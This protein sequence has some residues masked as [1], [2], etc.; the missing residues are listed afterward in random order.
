M[1]E[2]PGGGFAALYL[3]LYGLVGAVLAF[4]PAYHWGNGNTPQAAAWA[5]WGG[6]M[7]VALRHGQ[8]IHERALAVWI[9]PE[10]AE[11]ERAPARAPV[12]IRAWQIDE[13]GRS[14]R[15]LPDHD[16]SVPDTIWAAAAGLA[17]RNLPITRDSVG[18]SGD[19]YRQFRREL[20]TLGHLGSGGTI[21]PSGLAWLASLHDDTP[22]ASATIR[23]I[24]TP[25]AL[26]S[27]SSSDRPG[28]N[29]TRPAHNGAGRG[30]WATMHASAPALPD[31][32]REWAPPLLVGAIVGGALIRWLV[33]QVSAQG[34]GAAFSLALGLVVIGLALVGLT[35]LASGVT[36][37]ADNG[38]EVTE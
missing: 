28:T 8:R 14:A 38:H 22:P 35:W 11:A 15:P 29:G 7:L 33:T 1:P 21:S 10:E 32:V 3:L 18:A 13:G 17:A 24:D 12:T 26:S 31:W 34:A 30:G 6:I 20:D 19:H 25:P 37:S 5:V 2:A 4:A 36:L 23:R 9:E 27:S 16:S